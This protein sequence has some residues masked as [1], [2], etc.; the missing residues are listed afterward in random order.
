MK[1]IISFFLLILM[2]ISTF[3]Q[4]TETPQRNISLLIL[5]K[6]GRPM[7][8]VF[9]RSLTAAKGGFTNNKGLFVFTGMTETEIPFP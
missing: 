5:D 7:N 8:Q 3:S 9:V 4:K 2:S 6:K 1:Y